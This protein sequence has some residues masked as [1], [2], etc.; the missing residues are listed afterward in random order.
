MQDRDVFIQDNALIH[1]AKGTKCW[2]KKQ[3]LDLML[4]HIYSSDLNP[5]EHVWACLRGIVYQLRPEFLK[6]QY[7][8]RE[9][10]ALV[11]QAIHEAWQHIDDAFL[12]SSMESKGRRVQAATAVK[13]DYARYWVMI[14]KSH[15]DFV[16]GY[17]VLHLSLDKH[18]FSCIWAITVNIAVMKYV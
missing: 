9:T 4:W 13:G 8:N 10:K 1:R 14:K 6:T 5:M 2:T 11:V 18:F 12:W 7:M 17:Y 3:G 16:F 15:T